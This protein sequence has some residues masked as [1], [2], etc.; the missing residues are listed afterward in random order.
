MKLDQIEESAVSQGSSRKLYQGLAK[1]TPVAVNPTKE[2]LGKILGTEIDRDITYENGDNY[3]LDFWCQESTT[4]KFFKFSIFV[5]NE[6]VVSAKSGNMQYIN[7][8]GK[9]GYFANVDAVKAK[10][11]AATAEWQKMKMEGLRVAKKGEATLYEFLI[12]LFNAAPS[13][14][15]PQFESF[16]KIAMGSIKELKDVLE[17]AIEKGRQIHMLLGVKDGKYQDAW[18][19]MFLPAIFTSKSEQYLVK[20]ATNPD[21]PYKGEWGNDLA[22]REYIQEAPP[23]GIEEEQTATAGSDDL[24]W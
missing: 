15:F 24:P 17:A 6:D 14:P 7:A 22:F 3:R 19:G 5:S 8:Y 11:E 2:Q 18:T 4:S 9:T 23:A 13:K 21:Y 12:A 20:K 1:L 10:N 16:Q